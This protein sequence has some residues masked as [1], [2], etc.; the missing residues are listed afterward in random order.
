MVIFKAGEARCGEICHNIYAFN[1]IDIDIPTL[2]KMLWHIIHANTPRKKKK[3]KASKQERKTRRNFEIWDSP[4][5]RI[6]SR[7]LS[8]QARSCGSLRTA[9][10]ACTSWN[11]CVASSSFPQ[12]LSLLQFEQLVSWKKLSEAI[13]GNLQR[14]AVNKE[15]STN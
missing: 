10:A 15:G 1:P 6:A 3:K 7:C 5:R 11:C 12:F 13:Y 2:C 14:T 8:Y 9:Y 4:P